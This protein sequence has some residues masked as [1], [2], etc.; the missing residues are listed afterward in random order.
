MKP[1]T[2]QPNLQRFSGQRVEHICKERGGET[3]RVKALNREGGGGEREEEGEEVGYQ[4]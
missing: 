3:L 2:S 1:T 4:K